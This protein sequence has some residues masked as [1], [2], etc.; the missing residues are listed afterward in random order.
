MRLVQKDLM[1]FSFALLWAFSGPA[2]ANLLSVAPVERTQAFPEEVFARE[3][4]AV[5]FTAKAS[6]P[7][8]KLSLI[9]IDDQGSPLA[10]VGVLSDDKTRGDRVR[11]DG[12]YSLK[13]EI[14]GVRA[15]TLR[16]AVITDRGE[17]NAETFAKLPPVQL[18]PGIRTVEVRVVPRPSLVQILQQIWARWRTPAE[19]Q[20]DEVSY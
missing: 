2:S 5:L 19:E 8:A 15:T 11:A 6:A 7:D 12:I 10:Y 4:T 9:Q 13:T 17:I 1:M 20:P 16:F 18:E 14:K 3:G